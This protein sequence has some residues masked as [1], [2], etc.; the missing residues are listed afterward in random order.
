MK[1]YGSEKPPEIN[2]GNI[3]KVPVG[4][5]VGEYDKMATPNDSR[6]I[7]AKIGEAVTFYNE[8]KLGHLAFM[9]GKNMSYFTQD[10]VEFI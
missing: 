2:L 5:F 6:Y 7:R 10:V 1:I 9:V 4:M 8:Y 3:K